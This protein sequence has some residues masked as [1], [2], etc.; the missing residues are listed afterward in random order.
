[1]GVLPV[2]SPSTL[3]WSGAPPAL[4]SPRLLA[5][6]IGPLLSEVSCRLPGRP[7]VLLI[8]ATGRDHPR[9]A[10]LAVH[11]GTARDDRGRPRRIT[12]RAHAR[13]TPLIRLTQAATA[14]PSTGLLVLTCEFEN[15]AAYGAYL[16][17]TLS[18][19]EAQTHN[20]RIRE[21]EAPFLYESTAML[22]EIDLGRE[23][24]KVGRG[25]VLDA[26]FGRPLP[27]R[28]DDALDLTRQAF[29]ASERHGAVGCRL[30]EL[31]H[32]GDRSGLLCA[33][34][35]YNSM[36]EF[37]R[38]SDAWLADDGRRDARPTWRPQRSARSR[39][40]NA[41]AEDVGSKAISVLH[42][43]GTATGLAGQPAR[44]T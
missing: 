12:R 23:D 18:D 37:G 22:A 28:W 9:H 19:V 42:L 41:P 11:L 16:D 14:G 36:K 40:R 32:A 25:R 1:M 27:G 10:G 2:G 35:E 33:V 30:F 31:D 8:D 5:L 3:C 15:L 38:A 13:S 44:L 24:T 26:R 4:T 43:E 21:A 39:R 7:D 34:V 6:R 20:H 17:D 29:D